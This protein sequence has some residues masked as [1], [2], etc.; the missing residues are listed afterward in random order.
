MGKVIKNFMY[1][2]LYQIL[3]IVIPL[4]MM[5]YLSRTLGTT[6]IGINSYTTSVVTL[7]ST[8][9]MLG[10]NK[11]SQREIA[12]SMAKGKEELSKNFWSL[13][14]I[15]LLL[16]FVVLIVYLCMMFSSE[17][18]IYFGLQLFFLLYNFLDVSW[19]FVGIEEMKIVALRNSVVKII[20]TILVFVLIKD[21][22]DLGTYIV[23]NGGSFLLGAFIMLP[24]IRK[25]VIRVSLRKDDLTGHIVPVIKLFLPQAASS[26]YVLMD[27]TMIEWLTNN[28]EQV[29]FYDQSQ[30]IVKMP[31]IIAA[32][33]STVMLPRISN[34]YVKDRMD[35]VRMYVEKSVDMML[36]LAFPLVVGMAGVASCFIPWFLGNDFAECI[37]IMQVLAIVILPIALTNVTGLEYLMGCNLTKELTISYVSASIINVILNLSLIPHLGV[38]GAAVGTICAEF[39]VLAIQ[40]YYMVK[41]I[42]S[43]HLVRKSVKSIISSVVMFGVIVVLARNLTGS[44]ITTLVQVA[45]GVMVY[46]IAMLVLR[47]KIILEYMAMGKKVIKEKLLRQRG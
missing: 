8:I 45:V 19:F 14:I 20:A 43:M 18:C 23:I 4:I 7:F 40:Y 21:S 27:K 9:G 35:E 33:L 36:V 37:R 11:Y 3:V 44:I 47:D 42:G 30:N 12:Y 2:S 6:A 16:L 29:G 39:S 25:Y 5:P 13:L 41:G 17:Y 34:E 22:G 38:Y 46:F 31:L 28:V 15:R 32:S 24:S 1:N 10:L 26:I